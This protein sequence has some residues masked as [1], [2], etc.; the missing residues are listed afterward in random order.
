[1]TGKKRIAVLVSGRGSNLAALLERAAEP[2]FPG[3][4]SLVLSNRQQAP[5]LEVAR[6]W[7]VACDALP[8]SAFGNRHER[9]LEL[10]ARLLHNQI[11]LVVCAGYDQ[12]LSDDVLNAFPDAIINIH[13]SLLP[14]FGGGMHAV[15]DALEHGVRI[16]GCTAQLLEPG[17]ADGGPIILQASV[18]VQADDTAESLRERIHEQEWKILPEAVMLW[19]AG[20][21]RRVGRHVKI[22]KAPHE[23]T[24]A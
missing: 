21:L 4:I 5:A 6:A 18:H 8:V 15:E 22:S 16:T 13:P 11:D 7:N 9:D 3:E 2:S 1:M 12:L 10:R 24:P 19:C 20:R 17:E 14:S 23:V